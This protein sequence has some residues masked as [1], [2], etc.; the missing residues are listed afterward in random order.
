VTSREELI[1]A[2]WGQQANVKDNTL[3]VYVHG[4]RVKLE[5]G[6]AGPQELIRTIHGTGYIL[7]DQ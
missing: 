7:V 5:S 4:L 1:E 2:G 6:A 3:D